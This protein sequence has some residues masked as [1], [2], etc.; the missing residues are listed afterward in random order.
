MSPQAPKL[1]E[2]PERESFG[3]LL[4]K[5]A[6]ESAGLVRDE[7]ELGKQEFRE[8][9]KSLRSAILTIAVAVCLAFISL[10]TLDAALVIGIGKEIGYGISALVVGFGLVLASGIIVGIGISLIRRTK[11]KPEKTLHSLKEDRK[12]LRRR[13]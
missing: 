10:F 6:T 2:S 5:L 1:S 13:A 7:I 12:W 4:S 11:L 9:A 3:E 8:K